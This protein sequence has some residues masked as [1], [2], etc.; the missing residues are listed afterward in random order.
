M[1]KTI[2]IEEF[3]GISNRF[4]ALVL[5]FALQRAHGHRIVLDWRELDSFSV[6]HT[7]TQRISWWHKLGAVRLRDAD[8]ANDAD[9]KF[10]QVAHK[11]ILLRALEGPSYLLDP[12]YLDAANHIRLAPHLI[13]H[14]K[15]TLSPYQQK[16]IVGVHIRHGDY[17]LAHPHVY[18]ANQTEWPAVPLWWYERTM[19]TIAQAMP[20]VVF[21]IAGNGNP[22]D[23]APFRAWNVVTLNT[24]S[25]Y[26]YKGLDH[27]STI[28]P[29]AD[30]F[31]LAC[32]P[33]LLATP[34][35]G[36]SHWAANVLGN[37]TTC[38]VPLNGA[39]PDDPRCG[40]VDLYGRRLPHWQYAGR[41][42]Q[43][44]M[45]LDVQAAIQGNRLHKDFRLNMHWL[46]SERAYT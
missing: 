44:L 46:D 1:S 25:P 42:G 36:Y 39:T 8:F 14:I 27:K 40:Q 21:F 24:A 11:N 45:P 33:V 9:E 43:G 13:E 16:A 4:E 19:A 38:I 26:A 10:W 32:M 12:L 3:V 5:A 31:A 35:S 18:S 22:L 41:S 28:N 2:Y 15:Q 29:V 6:A 23:H 34:I 30:L 17:H 37:P 20:D 7:E